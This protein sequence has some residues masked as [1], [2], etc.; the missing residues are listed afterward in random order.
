MAAGRS[1]RQ[2]P[3]T[4]SV[5]HV[6]ERRRRPGLGHKIR[7]G[8][9]SYRKWRAI[10]RVAEGFC[11]AIVRPTFA[12]PIFGDNSMNIHEYQAK[13]VLRGFGAPVP[14]GKPAFTVEEAVAA[15][16]ELPGPG[17]GGQG[18]DPCRRPRQGRRRQGGQIHRGCGEGSPAHAGHD[19]GHASD[20]SAWPACQAHL[21]RGRFGDR[22]RALSLCAGGPRHQPH[23]F[24]RLHRRRH[25]HRGSGAQ[26]AGEY[27][28]LPDRTGRRLFALCRQRDRRGAGPERRQ[29]KQIG[30]VVK[31]LYDAFSP[32][33]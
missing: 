16:E 9:F 33:T 19:A 4:A 21:Y 26:D 6:P 3:R 32:R 31:S 22:A 14:K 30:Q 11:P 23:R 1:G 8:A 2:G 20:R 15:A 5:G 13:E 25:G 27:Q 28:D 7:D 10:R 24:H 29:A 12:L 18:P 17:L